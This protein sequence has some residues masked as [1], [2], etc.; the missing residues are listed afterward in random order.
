FRSEAR[1]SLVNEK[2]DLIRALSINPKFPAS[3]IARLDQEINIAP[4]L[5]DNPYLM[6]ARMK[7]IDTS[8]R[9]RRDALERDA[10]DPRMPQSQREADLISVR[11]INKFLSILGAPRDL[12]FPEELPESFRAD[13]PF[14]NE[15]E[16]IRLIELYFQAEGAQ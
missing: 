4:S 9:R 8:L 14:L 6:Q 15:E 10:Q 12:P 16:Q 1:Q 13:W 3:E 7:A 2:N 5:V 11:D